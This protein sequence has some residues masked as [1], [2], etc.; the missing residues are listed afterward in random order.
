MPCCETVGRRR[1]LAKARHFG[2]VPPQSMDAG[3]CRP[4]N[5]QVVRVTLN[6]AGVTRP[7]TYLASLRVGERTPYPVAPIT[8]RLV[9]KPRS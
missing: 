2:S 5:R 8:V 4:A 3:P 1:N 7:G 6:A 9:V